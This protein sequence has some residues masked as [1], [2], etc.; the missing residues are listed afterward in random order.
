MPTGNRRDT[1]HCARRESELT[2]ARS[3]VTREIDQ[4]AKEEK[5]MTESL[6]SGA[7]SHGCALSP[8]AYREADNSL[9]T[10]SLGGAVVEA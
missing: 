4:A 6:N 10:R 2:S 7:A 8:I 5:Q 3:P 9:S 1:G